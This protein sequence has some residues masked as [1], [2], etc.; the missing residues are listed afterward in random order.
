MFLVI[1]VYLVFHYFEL[2]MNGTKTYYIITFQCWVWSKTFLFLFDPPTV[3]LPF[4]RQNF[5]FL[6]VPL[7]VLTKQLESKVV[8]IIIEIIVARRVKIKNT[9]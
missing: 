3:P 1:F 5:S 6:P 4:Q 7:L 2:S 9:K 8:E